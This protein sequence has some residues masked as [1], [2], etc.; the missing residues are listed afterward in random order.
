M[1]DSWEDLEE[2]QLEVQPRASAPR[3]TARTLQDLGVGAGEEGWEVQRPP[4]PQQQPMASMASG[5]SGSGP[6][7]TVDDKP[8]LLVDLTALSDGALHNR[9]DKAGCNDADL[10]RQ[11][12]RKIEADYAKFELDTAL[13][14]S[15]VVRSCGSSVWRDALVELRDAHPGHF[16]APVFPP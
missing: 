3:S 7:Q 6:R 9:F 5:K 12:I 15:G 1:A 4:P 16:W 13:I 8:L 11:W 14:S 10:K 2:E